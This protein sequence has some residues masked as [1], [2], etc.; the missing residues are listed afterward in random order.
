MVESDN[1]DKLAA[2]PEAQKKEND[3]KIDVQMK[4]YEESGVP[5]KK[6]KTLEGLDRLKDHDTAQDSITSK[7]QVRFKCPHCGC[8]G[9]TNVKS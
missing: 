6:S 5:R 2:D 3:G 1:K 4:H 8:T 7:G 9:M